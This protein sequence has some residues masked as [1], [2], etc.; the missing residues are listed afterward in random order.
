[1]KLSSRH[2]GGPLWTAS[3]EGC[4]STTQSLRQRHG[5]R[6]GSSCCP[7]A[8]G[9]DD[10]LV[11]GLGCDLGGSLGVVLCDLFVVKMMVFMIDALDGLHDSIVIG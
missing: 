11:D 5:I 8:V 7:A 10:D 9:E 1:M 2:P 3:P 6:Y 4:T